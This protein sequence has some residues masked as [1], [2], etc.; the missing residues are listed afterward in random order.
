MTVNFDI[1]QQQSYRDACMQGLDGVTSKPT[2]SNGTHSCTPYFR[3]KNQ[4]MTIM[5]I[6]TMI[7]MQITNKKGA[8]F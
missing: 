5:N 7:I 1:F 3:H 6:I 4:I 2:Y 8:L